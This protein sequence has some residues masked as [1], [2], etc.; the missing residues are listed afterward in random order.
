MKGW[1]GTLKTRT[2]WAP[3]GRRRWLIAALG[4]CLLVAG[5]LALRG[6]RPD[7]RPWQ[8]GEALQ[9]ASAD[10]DNYRFQ[11]VLHPESQELA[12]T[13]DLSLKNR[14]GLPYG[15]ILLRTY[16]G[17]FADLSTSPL[18]GE[19]LYDLFY[20]DGFD[21]GGITL[22][23]VLWQEEPATHRFLDPAR[24]MLEVGIP[25]LLP[26]QSGTLRL[27]CVLRLPRSLGR[28][29]QND[30]VF[31]LGN[32]LPILAVRDAGGWRKDPYDPIGDPFVSA[33][34]NYLVS[35]SLP[36]GFHYVASAPL[37]KTAFALR[38]F[39][40]V[41]AQGHARREVL[42]EG[43]RLIAQAGDPAQA[44]TLLDLGRKA[45]AF[46]SR[47]Y[48]AYPWESLSI[49]Q[50]AFPLS[51]MEYPGLVI[52][53]DAYL[54]AGRTDAL[55]LILA[56]EIAHQWFY[57]MVGSDQVRQPWQ[58]EALCEWATLR[59][60]RASYGEAAYRDLKA[61]RI[62]APLQE[63]HRSGITAGSPGA[64]FMD[65]GEYVSLVY[66]KGA[67]LMEAIDL[68]TGR[69]DE[70]LRAYCEQFRFGPATRQDFESALNRFMG[71]DLSP[72]V[73]DYLDVSQ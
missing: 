36:D 3:K 34:A 64:R 71:R 48:G 57:A 8:A 30:G 55:E 68:D 38:D 9:T 59:F 25:R 20:P 11:L 31:T 14:S 24:T 72:L 28:F 39:A 37:D 21:A 51:G 17:A 12:V 58:D 73:G 15:D 40:L 27:R 16:A 13:M 49:A 35:L 61:L 29:G 42:V 56:H 69:L 44:E 66:G 47:S 23:D 22:H 6:T 52:V 63:S 7:S 1:Q 18:A 53:S 43:V 50:T 67:A 32:C 4:L 26:G 54:K 41:I 45:L 10:L 62:D 33:A 5:G 2:G 65:Y 60:V 46:Y 70:F 19:P